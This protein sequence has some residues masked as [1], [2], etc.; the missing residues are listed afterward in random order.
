VRA[1]LR[2]ETIAAMVDTVAAIHL[3][4]IVNRGFRSGCI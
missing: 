2:I 3:P 4:A 1:T